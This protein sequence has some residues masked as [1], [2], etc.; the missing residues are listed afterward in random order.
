MNRF[1]Q[2][3]SVV[4][5]LVVVGILIPPA[6]ASAGERPHFSGGTAQFT[7]TGFEGTGHAT[8]LGE[9]TEVGAVE[10]LEATDPTAIPLEGQSI[11]TAANGDELW[12]VFSG[13]LNG[14]T[15]EIDA[16]LT[17]VGGTGRFADASGSA[18]LVGQIQPDGTI[19]ASVEGTIDY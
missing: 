3:R 2:L 18:A 12:A 15:L 4:V 14:L 9:Y 8:H 6:G 16:T 13:H 5:L 11:Y 10:F 7:P 17:Y 19:A 1:S